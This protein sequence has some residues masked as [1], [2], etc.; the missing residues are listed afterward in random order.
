MGL[1]SYYQRFV[2]DFSMVAAPLARL[3]RQVMVFV[4]TKGCEASFRDLKV[5]LV[6]AL[7]LTMSDGTGNYVIF[8]DA[9]KKGLGCVL[10]QLKKVIAY[11]S[12]KLKDCEKNYPAHD[13]ELAVVVFA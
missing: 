13:L 12:K 8:I 9:S 11:A 7:L 5:R 2:Q 1:A 3:T 10:M 6:I 4:W